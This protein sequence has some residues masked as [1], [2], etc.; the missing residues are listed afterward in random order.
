[1]V[2]LTKKYS[3]ETEM[4]NVGATSILA[5]AEPGK[6]PEDRTIFEKYA[7]PCLA[8]LMGST[9]FVAAACLSVITNPEGAGPM[10]PALAHG[11]SL[12]IMVAVLGK[13]SGGHFN[14][15]VTLAAL[16]AGGLSPLLL[17]PY[18][19]CQLSGGMLGALLAKSMVPEAIFFNRTGGGCMVQEGCTVGMAVCAEL[20]FSFLLL[21]AVLM[22]SL[23]EH[24]K[25]PLA[26]FCIGF[27]LATGILVS[28]SISGSCLNPARAFGPALISTHWDNHWVYWIGPLT[29][30][31][32]ASVLYRTVLAGRSRRLFLK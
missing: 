27:A 26:P 28:G 14:P 9:L 4:E 16:A 2:L 21:L 20:T 22:G 8:E 10:G 12:G 32:L 23:A 5:Q 29:S 24:S 31:V 3:L 6:E 17:L 13:I 1:M 7:Q 11:F 30:A 25:T 15:A 19:L 18:W